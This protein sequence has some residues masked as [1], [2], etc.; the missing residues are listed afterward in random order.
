MS[1][2]TEFLLIS[3]YNCDLS[4]KQFLCNDNTTCLPL[5]KVCN[6][7]DDCPKGDDESSKCHFAKDECNSNT[8][9]KDARCH[10]LPSGSVCICPKGY[11]FNATSSKC[12]VNL[13]FFK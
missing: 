12:E 6:G 2:T 5:S 1:R 8:C 7:K 10:Y 9:P 3:A 13:E 11:S 4:T